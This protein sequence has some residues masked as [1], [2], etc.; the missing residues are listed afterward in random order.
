MLSCIIRT[1]VT[2]HRIISQGRGLCWCV[3]GW[4]LTNFPFMYKLHC[5]FATKLCISRKENDRVGN[6]AINS[7]LERGYLLLRLL[8]ELQDRHGILVQHPGLGHLAIPHLEYKRLRN[9]KLSS[10]LWC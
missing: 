6:P 10:T 9:I 2:S 3:W 5:F 1:S 7:F 4:L 8:Q